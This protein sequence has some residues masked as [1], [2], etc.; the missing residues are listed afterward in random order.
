MCHMILVALKSVNMCPLQFFEA[1]RSPLA[2]AAIGILVDVPTE[3][4]RHWLWGVAAGHSPSSSDVLLFYLGRVACTLVAHAGLW[5]CR[6]G[7]AKK[8]HQARI[9]QA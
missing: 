3:V 8:Q 5:W 2:G 9:K 7:S 4:W 1:P 6:R